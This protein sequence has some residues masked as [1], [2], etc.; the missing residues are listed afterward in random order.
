[1]LDTKQKR[2][3]AINI[4]MP[5]RQW[6]AEPSGTLDQGPRQSLLTYCS[7]VL[8]SFVEAHIN[9]RGCVHINAHVKT[10]VGVSA[11]P[12]TTVGVSAFAHTTVGVDAEAC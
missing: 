12:R 2:G 7:A 9:I 11:R 6:L 8:F 10:R 4:G 3:S 5:G 1:M